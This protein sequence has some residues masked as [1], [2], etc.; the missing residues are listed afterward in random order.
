MIELKGKE[1]RSKNISSLFKTERKQ[2]S[3]FQVRQV[4]TFQS[5][6]LEHERKRRFVKAHRRRAAPR[7]RVPTTTLILE[8][9][10]WR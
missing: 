6:V 4:W 5:V 3:V 9:S 1:E 10:W 8:E 7:R 2:K